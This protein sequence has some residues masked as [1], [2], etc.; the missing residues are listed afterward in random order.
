MGAQPTRGRQELAGRVRKAVAISGPDPRL[1][2]QANR[3]RLP[4]LPGSPSGVRRQPGEALGATR[5]GGRV[6]RR[7]RRRTASPADPFSS[8]FTLPLNTRRERS[9]P[10]LFFQE[11]RRAPPRNLGGADESGRAR[12][13]RPTRPGMGQADESDPRCRRAGNPA[14]RLLG[15]GPRRGTQ[16][17]PGMADRARDTSQAMA[18]P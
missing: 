5:P 9:D 14:R 12:T 18:P 7:G 6:L 4:E 8:P 17:R 16:G 11:T 2:A 15:A 13:A 1:D 3:D 10:P